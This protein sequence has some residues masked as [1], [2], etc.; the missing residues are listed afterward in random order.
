[1][2]S[3]IADFASAIAT[4]LFWKWEKTLGYAYTGFWDIRNSS[5]PPKILS[6]QSFGNSWP[7]TYI[8][9]N[10]TKISK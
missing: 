6:S 9:L 1:M 4:F 5:S 10:L 8:H 7:G 2:E 3:F